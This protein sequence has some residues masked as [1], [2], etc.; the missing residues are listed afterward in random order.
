MGPLPGWAAALDEFEAR[1]LAAAEILRDGGGR[2]APAGFTPPALAGPCPPEL[3]ARATELLALARTLEDGL[4]AELGA[5]R[6]ELR[7]LPRPPVAARPGPG[8]D[9]R[10]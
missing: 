5:V 7:R 8:F 4:R 10:A 2:P 6:E 3:R 9:S 1:L